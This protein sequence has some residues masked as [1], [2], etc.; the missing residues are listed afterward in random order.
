MACFEALVARDACDEGEDAVVCQAHLIAVMRA[1][2]IGGAVLLVGGCAGVGSEAPQ[3]QQGH[4]KATKQEQT[5][6]PEATASEEE[7]RCK[8]TRTIVRR[9]Y[10]HYRPREDFLTNDLP[11]CPK[12]GLLSGTDGKDNLY[13]GD[14]E[15][16]VRGLGGRDQLQGGSGKDV[17]YG[18]PG[19]DKQLDAGYGEDV[20]YGGP[21]DD[22]EFGGRGADVIYVG[23]GNDFLAGPGRDHDRDKLYC[24]KGKDEYAADKMDYV[25]SSC[26]KKPKYEPPIQ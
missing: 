22:H 5:R 10:F 7:A 12:G 16:K 6:S 3:K 18:G 21:G 26:E 19:D 23:D 24:G 2:V 25:D 17:I 8:G 14:G 20:I 9:G 15:D 11:G 4:T 13:G 1:F